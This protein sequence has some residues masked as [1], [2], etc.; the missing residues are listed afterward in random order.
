[1]TL[2]CHHQTYARPEVKPLNFD[3][4][5]ER[6][7][8]GR[9]PLTTWD[10][11][12]LSAQG[13]THFLDLREPDEWAAPNVGAPAVEAIERLALGR[14][15]VPM[16]DTQ[17]PTPQTLERAYQWLHQVLQD[18]DNRFYVHCRA[19]VERTAAVLIAFTARQDGVSYEDALA[20]L[21]EGRPR[22]RPL[23]GQEHAVREWLDIKK[24]GSMIGMTFD[25][26]RP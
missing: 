12:W 3:W 6:I 10:V 18:D 25:S 7:M 13:I 11:E 5:T 16:P 19:G 9:N 2:R 26:P 22:L 15:N 21:R 1:M 14:V 8:A 4:V 20:R 24:S 23:W 17:N